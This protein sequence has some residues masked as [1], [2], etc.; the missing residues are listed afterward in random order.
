VKRIKKSSKRANTRRESLKRDAFS[1]L[2]K[3]LRATR[4]QKGLTQ[5]DLAE[6]LGVR[7]RQISDL[8]RS[9]MDPRFSTVQDVARALEM[10]LVLIPRHLVSAVEGLQGNERSARTPMYALDVVDDEDEA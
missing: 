4:E 7:Q 2:G 8:E 1:T 9:A 3:L 5:K 6:R 10:E